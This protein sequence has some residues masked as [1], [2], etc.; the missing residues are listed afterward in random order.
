M[1]ICVEAIKELTAMNI[2]QCFIGYLVLAGWYGKLGAKI[3]TRY[4]MGEKKIDLA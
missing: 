4:G 3:I 2:K 1:R